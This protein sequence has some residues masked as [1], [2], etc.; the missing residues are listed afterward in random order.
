L[1]SAQDLHWRIDALKEGEGAPWSFSQAQSP[2][3]Q[4]LFKTVQTEGQ[5]I[6]LGFSPQGQ[7]LRM[8]LDHAS[9][10][11]ATWV[12]EL[13][14]QPPDWVDVYLPDGSQVLA[15]SLRGRASQQLEH[16]FFAVPMRLQPGENVLF[17]RVQSDTA[18]TLPLRVWAPVDFL[19]YVQNASILQ[20]L[21]FGALGAMTLYNFF[22]AVSLRDRRFGLYVLFALTLAMG[23]FSGNGYGRLYLWTDALAFDRVAQTFFLCLSGMFSV[24]FSRAFLQLHQTMRW[25][26]R[27]LGLAQALMLTI[28]IYLAASVHFDWPLQ[29]IFVLLIGV[30][31]PMGVLILVAGVRALLQGLKGARFFMLAWSVL[32]LGVFVASL[33]MLNWLPSNTLTLY[34]L[35]IASVLEMLLL[36]FALADIVLQERAQRDLAQSAALRLE[37]TLVTQLQ[38]TEERLEQAV[39]T[40][41]AQLQDALDRQQLLLDQYV[42]FGALI[43]H[44]FRNPLGIVQSQISLLRRQSAS[45]DTELSRRLDIMSSAVRR[46]V[47][48]FERWL[49]GGRLHHLEKDLHIESVRVDQWLDHLLQAHPHYQA[50]HR[51]VLVVSHD[52]EVVPQS[53]YVLADESLLEIAVLN[54][55]DNACKYAELGT[56]VRIELRQEAA[57]VG[58]AVIDQGPGIGPEQQKKIFEDYVRLQPEGP[59]HGIGLGLAFV[60]RIATVLNGSVELDSSLG[61]GCTFSLWLPAFSAKNPS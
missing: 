36:A 2:A 20:A 7:W 41:T 45:L 5:N 15:G 22:L 44:E 50:S 30:A 37:Q 60:R 8:T 13:A 57:R 59:V 52:P 27:T 6:N 21:Y 55:L 56:E 31:L 10:V 9:S 54:L 49:Q 48:L 18:L 32:W 14:Y 29:I 3:Q 42:R 39:Q 40:R 25:I 61:Q 34:A 4:R 51:V 23:I 46:L 47:Q 1:T 26:D 19:R 53:W 17:M 16:R 24:A 35:Q 58:I 12:L 43:S 33:R 38:A 11:P 28:A